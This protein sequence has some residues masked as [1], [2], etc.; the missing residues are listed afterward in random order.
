MDPGNAGWR[1]FFVTRL[2]EIQ[3]LKGW[4]AVFLD[5]L[6][7]GVNQI[8]L[9]GA[10]A[11]KYPDN[12][13]YR[14]AVRGFV[15]YLYQNYALPYNRPLLA[16]IIARSNTDEAIWFDYMQYLHGAMQERWAV[17]WN[18]TSYLSETNWKADMTLAEKTQSQG[19]YIILVAP[20]QQAD[21]NRQKFAFASYLLISNGKAAFRYSNSS[22]YREVWLYDN[23]K[24]QLGS[25]V[26]PRYQNGTAT[27]RR[28]FTNGYVIVDPVN[29]TATISTTLAATFTST[30]TRITTST[31]T[32]APTMAA[33]STKASTPT[34]A[35]PSTAA[36]TQVN[37]ST[38]TA[39]PTLAVTNT[40]ASTATLL[41]SPTIS[42]TKTSTQVPAATK[43]PSTA[44][45]STGTVYDNANS[46]FSYSPGWKDVLDASA[47]QGKYK[48]AKKPG[49]SVNFS[50]TGQTFSIIYYSA[51]GLGKMQVYLD[52]QL[53][54][55]LNQN[56]ATVISQNKWSYS[57]TLTAGTHKL[58]LLSLSDGGARVSL[59]AISVR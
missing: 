19:K 49:A 27:W 45:V 9:D 38:A 8:Q 54:S 25:P 43:I 39:V 21:T 40:K 23:Y 15:Q 32:S 59:D 36:A 10:T 55:T 30:P 57:G 47:F 11:A 52:D 51:P 4:S 34:S 7:A 46:A 31:S 48:V 3:Q 41:P 44:T 58:R 28:D 6:E 1:N 22:I 35:P 16:N 37:T 5:D 2:I 26:G 13:A 18:H 53:I 12:A 33:T 14:P 29:H 56:T 20:G 17:D 24:V 50:F 42:A